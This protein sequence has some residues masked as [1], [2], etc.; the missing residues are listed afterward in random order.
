MLICCIKVIKEA[1]NM[2]ISHDDYFHGFSILSLLTVLL[3]LYSF[4]LHSLIMPAII[5]SEERSY[6]Q[7][8]N[9]SAWNKT[10]HICMGS[11]FTQRGG[12]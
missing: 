4:S 9:I 2:M 3:S 10:P 7:M 1:N 11:C 12:D 6:F 5:L 8:M